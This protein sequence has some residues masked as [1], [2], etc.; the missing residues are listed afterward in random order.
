[1]LASSDAGIRGALEESRLIATGYALVTMESYPPNVPI[2]L[3][4]QNSRGE[5][6]SDM[7]SLPGK[8]VAH[9]KLVFRVWR[10]RR[11]PSVLFIAP[12]PKLDT[13]AGLAF[14]T[15]KFRNG[16]IAARVYP[17][18][19]NPDKVGFIPAL[20]CRTVVS[21]LFGRWLPILTYEEAAKRVGRI[22]FGAEPKL[23]CLGIVVKSNRSITDILHI[24]ASYR[25]R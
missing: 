7:K 12:S 21:K 5:I 2:I 15:E 24:L 9:P 18:K 10:S 3:T 19:V 14:L 1:M 20:T 22:R 13:R 8:F 17:P 25:S 6:I 16:E 11:H 23:V 4:L